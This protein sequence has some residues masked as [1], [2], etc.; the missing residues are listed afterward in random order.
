M[1]FRF[2]DLLNFEPLQSVLISGEKAVVEAFLDWA[3]KAANRTETD[4][5]NKALKEFLELV[6]ARAA[7]IAAGV[8]TGS[9]TA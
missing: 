9:E 5:D 4:V 7:E 1:S 6:S 3:E 8:D 2:K